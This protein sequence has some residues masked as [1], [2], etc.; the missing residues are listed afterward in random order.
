VIKALEKGPLDPEGIREATG[1][2]SR[3]LGEEGK[4]KGVT[5]TLPV[6]LGKLQASGDIRRVA[7][8]GRFDQ[9]RY[10]YALWRPNPIGKSHM[11]PEEINSELARRFFTWIGPATIAEFQTFSTLS[12]K[13]AKAAMEPLKLMS[14]EGDRFLMPQHRDEFE[15]FKAPKQSQYVLASIIDG[16]HLF[17]G[18]VQQLLEPG[19]FAGKELHSHPIYDRGRIVGLWEFDMEKNEIAWC[20]FV[21]KNK[22]LEKAVAKTEEFV[23]AQLGDARGYALDSIKSRAPR[24]AGIRKAAR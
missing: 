13:A 10:R 15:S 17:R 5:T 16:L 9:Q 7:T 12:G 18:D 23:R 14:L 3:S 20:S 21:P 24:I 1:T 11:T 4:K 22:D 2:A 8:N 19:D 6:A